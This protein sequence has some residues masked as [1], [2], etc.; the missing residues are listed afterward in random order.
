VR[1]HRGRRAA[2]GPG[3]KRIA[4]LAQP[5]GRTVGEVGASDLSRPPAGRRRACSEPWGVADGDRRRLRAVCGLARAGHRGVRAPL[6]VAGDPQGRATT[7]A[8]RRDAL[9]PRAASPASGG[10]PLRRVERIAPRSPN[11]GPGLAPIMIGALL[12]KRHKIPADQRVRIVDEHP[13]ALAD[14]ATYT[15]AVDSPAGPQPSPSPARAAGERA[16]M[17]TAYRTGAEIT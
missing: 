3:G 10:L 8:S 6:R 11:A 13:D 9:G 2:H 16:M 1:A 14:A 7:P 4:S 5:R 12:G 17:N 15:S